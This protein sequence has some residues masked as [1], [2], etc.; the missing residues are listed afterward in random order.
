ML[1]CRAPLSGPSHCRSQRAGEE[2]RDV[3]CSSCKCVCVCVCVCACLLYECMK[4]NVS[5][6]MHACI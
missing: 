6:C 4:L 1:H 3:R 5:V 2:L